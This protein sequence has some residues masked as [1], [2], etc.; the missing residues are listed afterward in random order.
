M[1][2]ELEKQIGTYLIGNIDDDGYLQCQTEEVA[3]GFGVEEEQICA[4]LEVIQSFDPPGVGA[5]DLQE[6][7][8]IQLRHLEMDDSDVIFHVKQWQRSSDKILGDLSSRFVGRRLF[9][10][11]DLDMPESERSD[12]LEAARECVARAGFDPDYYFI[13]DRA[14]DVPYYNYYTAEGAEPKTRIYVEDRYSQPQ[15]RE[16]SEVSQ[17]VRGLQQRY[18]LHRVCFPSEV[19]EEVYDLYHRVAPGERS[20]IH[21]GST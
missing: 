18:E 2:D 8:L 15:I 5:R 3:K 12:F 11:I 20:V 7:L 9:K 1:Q 4:V 17:V 21:A 19:K 13:E 16:I 10:A 14:S 6:S